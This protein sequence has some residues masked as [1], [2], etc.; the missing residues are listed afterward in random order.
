MP[1]YARGKIYKLTHPHTDDIYIGSTTEKYLSRRLVGH[2][3]KYKIW[4][5]GKFRYVTSF[6]LFE[7]GADDVK[8]ELIECCPCTCK[9]EL[10]KKEGEHI[11]GT[12][13]INKNVAGRTLTEYYQDNRETILK[14]VKEYRET[15]KEAIVKKAKEYRETNK[16]A[17]AKQMKEYI[18]DNKEA[19][20]KQWK[21]Y[22]EANKEAIAKKNK[23]RYQANRETILKKAKEYHEANKE[24]I[25]K[26]M[27]K[28]NEDNKA[29]RSQK[30]TCVCGS[31]VCKSSLSIH[32]KSEKHKKLIETT[33]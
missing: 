32:K 24:A 8:I 14:K 28:Y 5:A 19:M 15:N 33:D 18:E 23:E 20:V 1:N 22:Y 7:L 9:E 25:S 26:R 30:V 11:K 4:K 2:K 17:I 29:K 3:T 12:K 16:E 27:K 31:V 21:E 13:C 10:H 6:K